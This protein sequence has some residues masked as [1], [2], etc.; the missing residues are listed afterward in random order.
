MLQDPNQ[1]ELLAVDRVAQ[2]TWK[3]GTGYRD[4][5][6]DMA[7]QVAANRIFLVATVWGYS[8][9]AGQNHIKT[10]EASLICLRPSNDTSVYNIL[11]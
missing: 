8:A 11:G 10:P 7:S 5:G 3:L 1:A 4:V 9:D 2:Y 6:N